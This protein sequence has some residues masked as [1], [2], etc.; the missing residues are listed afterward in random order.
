MPI[1]KGMAKKLRLDPRTPHFKRPDI[2]NLSK[3]VLDN[4]N[5]ICFSDDAQVS[6]LIAMKVYGQL[7]RT[8]LTIT[9][10]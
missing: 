2:D 5:S 6:I 3:W 7:P 4:A 8:E 1:P 9:E 10:I